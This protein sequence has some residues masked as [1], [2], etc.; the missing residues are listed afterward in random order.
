MSTAGAFEIF[1][2][3]APGHEAALGEEARACGFAKV[4]IVTGGVTIKGTWPEAWR[5]NLDLRGA[6]RV[7]ARIAMFRAPRL[8][9]LDE[10]A[11]QVPWS[12]ILRPDAPFRV[13]AVCR[14]S[15]IYHTG[16]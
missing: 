8:A 15:R 5:A 10:R 6:G 2:V 3:A 13:E 9:D 16:A 11:R 7:L 12:G 4:R 14:Q 1:L